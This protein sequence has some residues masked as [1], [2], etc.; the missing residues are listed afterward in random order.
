MDNNDK[1]VGS[2]YVLIK[3]DPISVEAKIGSDNFTIEKLYYDP[4]EEN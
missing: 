4:F 3:I 1:E 2:I